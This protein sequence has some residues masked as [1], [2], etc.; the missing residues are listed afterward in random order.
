MPNGR[1]GGFAIKRI[2]LEELLRTVPDSTTVGTR[3]RGDFR[4]VTVA[5]VRRAIQADPR[6]Q[7]GVE[8][9]DHVYYIVHLGTDGE[10]WFDVK[11][12]TPLYAQ[13]RRHHAD[14]LQERDRP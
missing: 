7:V 1:S 9:Q 6:D 14:G 10:D 8:E 3:F 4:A 2:D 11:P 5:E 13:F 12:G